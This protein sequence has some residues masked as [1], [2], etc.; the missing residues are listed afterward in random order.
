MKVTNKTHS[1]LN[2]QQLIEQDL[3]NSQ[4]LTN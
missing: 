2:E 4:L 1:L 3:Q